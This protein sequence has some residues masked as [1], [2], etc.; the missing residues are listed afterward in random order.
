MSMD[1][2]LLPA[3]ITGIVILLPVAAGAL[4]RSGLLDTVERLRRERTMVQIVREQ[5]RMAALPLPP[6]SELSHS[7]DEG[8]Q[9]VVRPITAQQ[10]NDGEVIK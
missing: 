2:T 4:R 8:P 3:V 7:V 6:G 10:R 5:H 9:L 1:A